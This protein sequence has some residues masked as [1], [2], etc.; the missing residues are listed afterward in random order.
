MLILKNLLPHQT[1]YNCC[2][3][4]V[5]L[6]CPLLDATLFLIFVRGYVVVVPIMLY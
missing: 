6:A 4:A 5:V 3:E 2:P 1:P